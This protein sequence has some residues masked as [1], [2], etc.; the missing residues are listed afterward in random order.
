MTK[1]L[2]LLN[3]NSDISMCVYSVCDRVYIHIHV[4]LYMDAILL[5]DLYKYCIKL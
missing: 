2:E 5:V 4:Y 1:G 3:I